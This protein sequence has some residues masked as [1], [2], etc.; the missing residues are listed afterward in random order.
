MGKYTWS[1][2]IFYVRRNQMPR[3][4]YILGLHEDVFSLQNIIKSGVCAP[5]LP[6]IL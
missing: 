6:N 3:L 2:V 1:C 4:V 5:E